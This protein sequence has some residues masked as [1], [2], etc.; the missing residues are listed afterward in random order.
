MG[1]ALKYTVQGLVSVR[2]EIGEPKPNAEGETGSNLRSIRLTVQD[3]GIGISKDFLENGLFTPFRQENSHSPG[4]GL[5]LSIVQQIC[6]DMGAELNITS[7]AGKGTRSAVDLEF[8]FNSDVVV[9]HDVSSFNAN[10]SKN[11]N[12]NTSRDLNVDRFHLITSESGV[13]ETS[14]S[15]IASS[16]SETAKDWLGCETSQGNA[17][18][19]VSGLGVYAIAEEDLFHW[20]DKELD[21]LRSRMDELA[22]VASHVLVLGRSLRSVSSAVSLQDM[23]VVPVFVHQPYVLYAASLFAFKVLIRSQPLAN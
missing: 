6:T 7:E 8:S 10:L 4:T 5:G 1:N 21:L 19:P 9:G 3:T 16:I 15:A 2:L 14:S 18:E 20:A 13:S 11:A 17:L 12:D 23:P 22:K